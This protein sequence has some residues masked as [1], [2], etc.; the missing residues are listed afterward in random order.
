M[1]YMKLDK[2]ARSRRGA[3]LMAVV[4]MLAFI[5]FLLATI[6][7]QNLAHRQFL[8]HREQQLQCSWL[9]HAG[10]ELAISKLLQD[11]AYAGESVALLPD[12]E[13]MITVRHERVPADLIQI[14]CEARFPSG[15][16]DGVSRS[17]TR[18]FRR[19]RRDGVVT[20]EAAK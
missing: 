10:I 17:V 7:R 16:R 4:V 6:A 2:Q 19:T 14:F 13:A 8:R 18:Q 1:S 11:P 3:V 20:F 12:S 15:A 9:A 5:S